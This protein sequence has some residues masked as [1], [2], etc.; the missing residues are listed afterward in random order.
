M[1]KI[2]KEELSQLIAQRNE[3]AEETFNA[4]FQYRDSENPNVIANNYF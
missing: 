4:M 2:T 1:N 3:Y